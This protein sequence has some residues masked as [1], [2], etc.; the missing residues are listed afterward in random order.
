MLVLSRRPGEQVRIGDDITLTVIEAVGGRI[1]LGIEAPRH[2]P[3]MRGELGGSG[4]GSPAHVPESS[5][6]SSPP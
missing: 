1:K 3:I 4:G 5:V 2:V 6:P